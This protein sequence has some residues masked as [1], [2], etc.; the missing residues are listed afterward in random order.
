MQ[1]LFLHLGSKGAFK[2]TLSSDLI[3]CGKPIFGEIVRALF[4]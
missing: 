1:A 4:R 3:L 2:K